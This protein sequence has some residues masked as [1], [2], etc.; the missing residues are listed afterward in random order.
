MNKKKS[1]THTSKVHF[2]D[3]DY[4][5]KARARERIDEA[6]RI[7]P[8]PELMAVLGDEEHAKKSALC[9]FHPDSRPSFSVYHSHGGVWR[10]N[11]FAC[12]GSGDEI[13]YLKA[14]F[15]LPT[16]EAMKEF[17]RLVKKV[18]D[19]VKPQKEENEGDRNDYDW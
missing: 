12:Y 15:N 2:Y 11:C 1:L 5:W 4:V 8:L 3:A 17:F 9:P 10:W 13:D 7:L 6:K 14:K 19:G 16:G 18:E